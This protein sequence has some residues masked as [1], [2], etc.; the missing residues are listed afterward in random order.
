MGEYCKRV[1]MNSYTSESDAD[2]FNFDECAW[3]QFGTLAAQT[4]T[5][6]IPKKWNKIMD[7]CSYYCGICSWFFASA[8]AQ[9]YADVCVLLLLLFLLLL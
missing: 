6:V 7:D 2:V 8:K 9:W 1:Y 5:E 4:R 3:K